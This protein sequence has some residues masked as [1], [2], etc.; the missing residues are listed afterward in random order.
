MPMRANFRFPA[1]SCA[2]PGTI[3]VK[4]ISHQARLRICSGV[5]LSTFLNGERAEVAVVADFLGERF[6]V[7]ILTSHSFRLPGL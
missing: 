2:E 7:A 1:T 5:A 4:T 3:T 6:R